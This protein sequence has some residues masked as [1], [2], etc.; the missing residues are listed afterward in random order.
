MEIGKITKILSTLSLAVLIG[1]V[2]SCARHLQVHVLFDRVEGLKAGDSV[3]GETQKIGTVDTPAVH[4]EGRILVPLKIDQSFRET[5]TDQSR[6]IIQDDPLK[7]STRAVKVAQLASIGK[8]LRDGAVV[9]G[10]SFFSFLLEKSSRQI[11]GQMKSFLESL[12]GFEKEIRQFAD[13]KWTQAL[14]RQ[15]EEW[16]RELEKSGEEVRRRFREEILPRLEEALRDLRRRLMEEG[17]EKTT[18]PLEEKLERIR[19]LVHA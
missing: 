14:E 16:I 17:K 11:Q 8:P 5:I 15:M 12:E 10:S 7:P 13:R 19:R 3:Y 2:L 9:E 1:L 4:P 18:Y 6:F